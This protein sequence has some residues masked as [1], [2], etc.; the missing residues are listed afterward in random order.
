[1]LALS[2]AHPWPSLR[3]QL[4]PLRLVGLG[5]QLPLSAPVVGRLL[6]RAGLTR[7]VLRHGAPEGTYTD[8]DLRAFDA[9]MTAPE[10]AAATTALYRTFL[11]REL[12]AL[13]AGRY[14]GATLE[15]QT[16]LVVG[17]NDLIARNATLGGF[18]KNAPRMTVERVPKAGHFLPEERPELVAARASELFG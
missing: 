9:R 7:R 8:A 15:V 3:D 5:Y 6:M 11:L 16:R 17:E 1:L 14:R 4:N 13:A 18:E 2:T 10:G 12:P